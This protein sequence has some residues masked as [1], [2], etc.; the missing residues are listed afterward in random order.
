ME[1]R[2]Q[3]QNIVTAHESLSIHANEKSNTC[4]TFQ[5][6]TKITTD[7]S[8]E[9]ENTKNKRYCKTTYRDL[10]PSHALPN[11]HPRHPVDLQGAA[12][13]SPPKQDINRI[14]YW[15]TYKPSTDKHNIQKC[16][17]NRCGIPSGPTVDVKNYPDCNSPDP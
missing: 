11:L 8:G 4:L 6:C 16:L 5:I 2:R 10:V 9:Y 15:I 17:C 13:D 1:Y 7:G 14:S 3:Q 12:D